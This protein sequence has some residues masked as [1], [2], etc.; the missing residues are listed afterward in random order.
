MPTLLSDR[1]N[2]ARRLWFVGRD[3]E[4]ALFQSALAGSEPP[5]QVLYVYGPGGVGKTTLLGEFASL[6]N[7]A[8]FD[9]IQIDA[10]NVEPSPESFMAALRLALHLGQEDSP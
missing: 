6:C 8:R 4:R 10:R 9:P 2:A 5:F 7:E 1:L 3:D